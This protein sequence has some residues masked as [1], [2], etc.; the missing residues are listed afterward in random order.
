M[1]DEFTQNALKKGISGSQWL[2]KIPEIIS[3]YEKLWSIQVL[4]PF[5]LSY[6]YVAPATRTDGIQVVLKIGF[7]KDREFQTEIDALTVFNG[8]GIEKILE[9][10]KNNAVMLIE[11]V[12]PGIPLSGME[13]DAEATRILASVMKKLWKPVPEDNNFITI[14]DWTADLFQ[15]QNWYK[16]TTG[17]FPEHL[18]IKA[19]ELFTYLIKTQETPMLVHGDLH[20]DN[21]LSSARDKW[22][23]IDPKGIVAEPCYEAAAMIRNPYKKLKRVKDLVPILRT[24]I[25]I[26]SEE[27]Q[28][29]PQ[30]ILE[31]CFAQTV[32]SA[33]WNMEGVKGGE[34]AI[35][36]AEALDTL[37][38][39]E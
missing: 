1:N 33:V 11:R 8:I 6:N 39:S 15:V 24:R 22:L 23:A 3:Q 34:H 5:N 30:R 10:D 25:L 9:V 7:P 4:S 38:F 37:K 20:H 13:D 28:F 21:I 31:W 17:P 36:V 35:R 12:S 29:K 18:I 16:G 19:Q 27:L 2:M 26:L 32:L 14:S